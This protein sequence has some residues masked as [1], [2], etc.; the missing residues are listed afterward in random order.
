MRSLYVKP[1]P[2]HVLSSSQFTLAMLGR[3]FDAATIYERRFH[4]DRRGLGRTHEGM[5][6][7]NL[8]YEK[9]T[10]TIGSFASAA[11]HL[12]MHV[13]STAD[14]AQ[15]S[16]VAKGESLPDTI[17]ITCGYMP[18]IIV[19]RHPHDKGAEDAAQVSTV[20]IINGGS[21]RG[22]H[23]TQAL[24]DVYTIIRRMEK[25]D[26][27]RIIIGGDLGSGRTARSLALMLSMY[28]PVEIIFVSPGESPMG[29]DVIDH[30]KERGIRFTET[31]ELHDAL[32]D[33]DVVYW[34]RVQKERM[35][36]ELYEKIKDRFI[37]GKREMNLL[38]KHAI[39]MHPLPRV[40]EIIA[41]EVD[42]DSRARYF[43]QAE[44]GLWIRMA[45]ISSI[46]H[47]TLFNP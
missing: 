41:E 36:P 5:L 46:L 6:L 9:S 37:I 11:A 1:I 18:D 47:G 16:S 40:G 12:G 4:E 2:L 8:F 39:L 31:Q 38:P 7:V 3:L 27:L 43:E 13:H 34:T 30:L 26:G 20:P 10:R 25:I 29:R 33:A 42:N 28:K 44:N 17:R 14:A 24:L 32:K 45:L 22:E 35:P 19:L 21:G 23:P 15:T